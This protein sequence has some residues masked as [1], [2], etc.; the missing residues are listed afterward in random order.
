MSSRIAIAAYRCEIAG[1]PEESLDIQVRYFDDPSVD[2]ESFLR[3]EPTHSY[4]NDR[5]EL[6]AWPFVH[7]LAIADFDSPKNG[8]EIAG[9]IT[10]CK[11]F[12]KWALK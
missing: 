9:F 8:K 2:I 6:V 1:V 3:D 10:G 4:S 12:Q 11:E 7:V 5:G